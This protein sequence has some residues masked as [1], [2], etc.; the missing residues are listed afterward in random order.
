VVSG[1][2]FLVCGFWLIF[3]KARDLYFSDETKAAAVNGLDEPRR[4]GVVL[5]RPP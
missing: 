4:G 1:L 2:W 5:Q 3:R